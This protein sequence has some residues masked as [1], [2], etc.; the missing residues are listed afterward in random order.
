MIDLSFQLRW[1]EDLQEWR[2]IGSGGTYC[3]AKTVADI[4]KAVIGMAGC[5]AR[6]LQ[7]FCELQ[8]E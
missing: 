6:S 1:F 5:E 7:S 2:V 8:E 4:P 3:T